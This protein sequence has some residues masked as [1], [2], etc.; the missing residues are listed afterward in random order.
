LLIVLF[1]LKK[2]LIILL[3]GGLGL[4]AFKADD[5]FE[6]S[7]NLEIFADVYKQVNTSYVD[8]VKPGELIRAAIN[9]MLA[10]LDPYT[11]F[12]SEAQAEEY[13]Y[14]VTG[15]FAGIGSSI[16]RIGD[17]IYIESPLDD[18]PAQKAGLLPGDKILE[19]D[20]QS[21]KGKK[22]DEVTDFL[23]GK[24]GT[25]FNLKIE[26][27]GAGILDK[28]ITRETIKVKN[29]P[30]HGVIEDHIGFIKLTGFT[31]NAGKE[32]QDALIDLKSKGATKVVL[33]LRNNGGGLLHEAVNIVN[34]F[35]PK[36]TT[37]VVT[38]GKFEEDNRTY[39]TLNSPVDTEIPLVILI[40]N[41]S[42]SASEIVSGA[43]QDLDR[44]IL[45]GQNS[46]GKGLVQTTMS[47]NYNTSM[48][49]TTAKYY[50][51]SGRLIQRLDYGN[52]VNGKAIAVADSAKKE[53]STKNGRKVTDGEGI[54]PD[55]PVDELT[56]SKLAQ[57]LITN[58]L[59]FKFAN[60]FRSTHESIE[61]ALKYNV[62]DDVFNDFKKFISDKEYTYTT[63]TER[64]LEKLEKQ[65][66]E[67]KYFSLLEEELTKLKKALES[68]KQS[69]LENHQEELKELLEY[70]IVK[71]YYFE[72]GKVEVGFDD[73]LEW[74]KAK[75]ILN[76]SNAYNNLLIVN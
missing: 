7:K 67:E 64:D 43:L 71:R 28:T 33:D 20:G 34:I 42:A 15:T 49:V 24:A 3:F 5:Y 22:T 10:S 11:N 16:R 53:Y 35:V 18:F 62:S 57:A 1:D 29:V 50:I 38:K 31:P 61:E 69:D 21:M 56:Y 59:L 63:Q 37:I 66:K 41:N 76:N 46:F 36:G 51:P 2:Y 8:E 4:V 45:V 44:A 40:N 13:R 70:E 48:K 30:Y 12:Y 25:S 6:I 47:L 75:S 55:V 74:A 39:K 58:D 65:A 68:T 23:K 9:G 73:D 72:K 26:R 27:T 54:Q 14:Q 52:K 19:V 17:Y 60:Q 32:V